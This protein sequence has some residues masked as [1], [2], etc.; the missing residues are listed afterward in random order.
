MAELMTE[1]KLR[2][3]GLAVLEEELGPV[4]ALRFL[5]LVR[6]EP[7]DYQKWREEE[8]AGLSVDELFRRL[9]HAEA[10]R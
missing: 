8:F 10:K 2:E 1:D 9:E 5:A 7:F 4:E 6:H 3:I